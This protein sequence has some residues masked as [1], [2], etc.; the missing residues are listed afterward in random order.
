MARGL[1]WN[2]TQ[3]PTTIN[4]KTTDGTGVGTFTTNLMGLLPGTTYYVKAYATNGIGTSYGE[5]K[6]F[7]M[8]AEAPVVT[9]NAVSSVTN[10]TITT[11][12]YIKSDGGSA[13]TAVG[14]CWSTTT[15]PTV[16]NNKT[17]YGL[18]SGSFTSNISGLNSG[19]T[20][21]IR[22]YATNSAGTSYGQ[23]LSILTQGLSQTTFTDID[24]N[25]YHA[26]VIGTQ[27]WMAENLK[28]TKYRNGDPIANVTGSWSPYAPGAYCWYNN[29]AT[30]KAVYGALYNFHAVA[31]S[32]YIAPLGW[33]VPTDAEWTTLFDFL[34]GTMVAGGKLK[35][36][37]T[38]HWLSPNI[39]ATNSSGFTALPG[40]ERWEYGD[41]FYNVGGFGFWWS[42]T[43]YG[44][45]DAWYRSLGQKTAGVYSTFGNKQY[46]LSVRCVK[47]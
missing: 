42:S 34:G 33:H 21:Y 23:Q 7:A 36:T 39:G 4:S 12:G 10:T 47:D 9:T 37:G 29:I 46:G 45:I 44:S 41:T 38:S 32:R 27:T 24:G 30:Y 35:E 6:K 16:D 19:T 17:I 14:V 15:N 40:G 13:I 3:N 18:W 1:C 28:T 8:L 5:Q 22:A 20:Y 43:Q 31:D 2:T 26:V 11:G 25:V